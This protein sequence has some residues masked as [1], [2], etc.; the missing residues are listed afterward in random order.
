MNLLISSLFVYSLLIVC[1]TGI[2]LAFAKAL[3][4]QGC[5]VLIM[6]VALHKDA[7]SW[8]ES[9]ESTDRSPKVAFYRSD[10]SKWT[11]LENVFD[12]YEEAF[13]GVPYIVCPGAGI[14]EPVSPQ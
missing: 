2:N 12:V 7:V 4:E 10:V 11:E 14:Y 3:H 13:G 9:L 5:H 6:D 8:M 1:A